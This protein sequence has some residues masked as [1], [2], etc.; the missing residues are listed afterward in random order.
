MSFPI[1]QLISEFSE[2]GVVLDRETLSS[3]LILCEGDIQKTREMIFS[4]FSNDIY[5]K[6]ILNQGLFRIPYV[7]I[8]FQNSNSLFSL[9]VKSKS[10]VSPYG[11]SNSECGYCKRSSGRWTYGTFVFKSYFIGSN[12]QFFIVI[13]GMGSRKLFVEHYQVIPSFI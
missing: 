10:V 2:L 6:Y 9:I 11:E 13:L 1:D 3:L 7:W 5:E 12:S 8:P 4:Q